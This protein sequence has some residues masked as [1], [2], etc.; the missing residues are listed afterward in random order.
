[1]I[2]DVILARRAIA[3]YLRKIVDRARILR[4]GILAILLIFLLVAGVAFERGRRVLIRRSM[5]IIISGNFELLVLLIVCRLSV[6][7]NIDLSDV[8]RSHE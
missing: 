8:L 4:V 6:K 1:M 3:W 5:V 7:G 2:V